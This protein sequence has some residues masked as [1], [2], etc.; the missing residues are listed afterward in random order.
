MC[1]KGTTTFW[2]TSPLLQAGDAQLLHV[3]DALAH[4]QWT[5][6]PTLQRQQAALGMLL[7]LLKYTTD[8]KLLTTF[9]KQVIFY[10][11]FVC[12]LTTSLIS[13]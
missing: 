6:S 11:L 3:L 7:L 10:L 1:D 5:Q 2:A 9:A 8:N 13:Y 12:L 4:L